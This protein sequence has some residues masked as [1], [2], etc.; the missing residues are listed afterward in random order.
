MGIYQRIKDYLTP[1]ESK[2]T[3]KEILKWLWAAWKGN[4]LQA[5]LNASIGLLEV[6]FSLA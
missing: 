4:R 3:A 1:E 6:A 5:F 2:Y